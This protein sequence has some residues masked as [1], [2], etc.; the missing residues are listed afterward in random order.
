MGAC[1]VAVTTAVEVANVT[2]VT[3]VKNVATIVER[4]NTVVVD[5]I[6]VVTFFVVVSVTL[7]AKSF[8]VALCFVVVGLGEVCFSGSLSLV[9]VGIVMSLIIVMFVGKLREENKLEREYQDG[10]NN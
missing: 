1:V 7:S 9:L 2:E 3:V 5:F 4:S 6:V 8:P 10:N